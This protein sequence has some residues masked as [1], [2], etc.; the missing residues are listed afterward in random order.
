MR[1][2]KT[3]SLPSGSSTYMKTNQEINSPISENIC[4]GMEDIKTEEVDCNLVLER[5]KSHLDP[6]FPGKVTKVSDS[7]QVKPDQQ[8]AKVKVT[9]E[10]EDTPTAK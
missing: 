3:T 5:L 8:C 2:N 9:K 4:H 6:C 7:I 10:P 1:S